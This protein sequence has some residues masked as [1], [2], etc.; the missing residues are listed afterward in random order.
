V[1]DVEFEDELDADDCAE[2]RGSK[3]RTSETRNEIRIK[4]RA[5]ASWDCVYG[6][7]EED[8]EEEGREAVL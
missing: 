4:L 3:Q 1:A 8:V 6:D 5:I 2:I 7:A